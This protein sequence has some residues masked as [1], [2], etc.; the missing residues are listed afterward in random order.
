MMKSVVKD[1]PNERIQE[2][3]KE[4]LSLDRSLRTPTLNWLSDDILHGSFHEISFA[5][6]IPECC[7]ETRYFPGFGLAGAPP[8]RL[9]KLL[10]VVADRIVSRFPTLDPHSLV[11]RHGPGAVADLKGG[12]DKYVFPTWPDKL[13]ALFPQD[14]HGHANLSHFMDEPLESKGG[15]EAPAKISAVPKS[16][17][18]PRLITIEPTAHQ[19][20]QQ[21]IL[22][23]FRENFPKPLTKCIDFYSQEP[24]RDLALAASMRDDLTTIDLSSASDRLSLWTVERVFRK[25]P[26]IL[27]ALH[28]TRSRWV[29]DS[30]RTT[31]S[32]ELAIL[33]KYAGQ[34]N[35]TTFP[36]QSIC[37]AVFC[38]ASLLYEEGVT[39]ADRN[40]GMKIDRAVRSIRVFGDDIIMPSSG[41]LWLSVILDFVQ[42]KVNPQ[43]THVSG[44]FRES[45]GL[46]AYR[47]EK[48]TP[49]YMQALTLSKSPKADELVSWVD[50]C[51]NAHTE[52]LWS[53]SNWMVTQI[54][55]KVRNMILTSNSP[56]DGIRF[57]T[58]CKGYF[59]AGR[60]RFNRNLQRDEALCLVHRSTQRRGD[61][62]AYGSLLQYF[63]EKPKPDSKYESGFTIS[64]S[65][66]K[67]ARWVTVP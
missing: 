18:G 35:A 37:Y 44:S 52:G 58:F 28:A 10:Q 46:D 29:I 26:T 61:R 31:S 4:F 51:N 22:R 66:S 36:V 21:G 12:E 50:V 6:G 59:Y 43:K 1:A 55:E 63:V 20:L 40:I 39:H 54:S 5:D 7:P 64:T 42:L 16:F 60:K 45:C 48:V 13:E 33:R 67:E 3:V 49:F 38:I 30:T 17:K 27:Q 34:G 32:P 14:H 24:S 23:W 9:L 56:G 15:T 62:N 25:N 19:Y 2:H 8:L 65:S 53:L 57:T 47:G 41:G 11:G